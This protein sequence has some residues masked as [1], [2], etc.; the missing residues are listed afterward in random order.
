MTEDKIM[1]LV[2]SLY[3]QDI[4]C[5]ILEPHS[6]VSFLKA[7]SKALSPSIIKI[8]FIRTHEEGKGIAVP[9]GENNSKHS[10]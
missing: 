10:G 7:S 4:S 6:S 3:C 9:E 8:Q 5:M 2:C 1:A